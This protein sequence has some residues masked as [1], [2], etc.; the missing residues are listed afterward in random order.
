MNGTPAACGPWAAEL[1]AALTPGLSQVDMVVCPPL[2][3]IAGMAQALSDSQVAWGAQD[4]SQH[5]DGAFT[6]ETSA[7][8]LRDLACRWVIVGHSERRV[9]LGESSD[10]VAA[11]ASAVVAAGLGAIVCVGESLADRESGRTEAV[12]AEQLKPLAEVLARPGARVVLAYEPVWAIGT[13]RSASPAQA[14]EVHAFIRA[15]LGGLGGLGGLG[16]PVQSLRILYG[17]SVKPDN[18]AA[19]FAV[20]G[21]DGGLIGGASLKVPEFIAICQAAAAA[22]RS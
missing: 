5:P 17:G 13:G 21:I 4:V 1:V 8:L 9:L 15:H 20:P 22:R 16:V 10:T 3:L 12:I 19:L 11:K 6:G 2:A 18:A 14:G 7:R